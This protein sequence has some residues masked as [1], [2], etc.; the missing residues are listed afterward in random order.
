MA[1]FVVLVIGFLLAR[2]AGLIGVDAV[3]SW[4]PAL[5]VGLALMFLFTGISHFHPK[6]RGE[7]IDMVPP[8]LPRAD[9]LVTLTG[10]LELA[11]AIGLLIP[12]TATWAA[13]ALVLLLIA[14]YPA[15]VSA[16]RRKVAQGDPIGPRTLWQLVYISA[17]LLTLA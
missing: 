9:L 11:G 15:N 13:W 7:I 6:L 17:A 10:A 14:L 3:D 5:R 4:Q 2:L 1:P 16:A 8:T 12:A